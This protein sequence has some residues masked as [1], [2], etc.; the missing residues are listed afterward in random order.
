MTA[1]SYALKKSGLLN[2]GFAGQ[3]PYQSE[4]SLATSKHHPELHSIMQKALASITKKEREEI[5]EHWQKLSINQGLSYV[6]VFKYSLI[7]LAILSIFAY[8]IYRLRQA[9]IARKDSE[10]KL[11]TILDNAPIG[12]WLTDLNSHYQFINK[13]LCNAVGISEEQF[14]SSTNLAALVGEEV[15]N[16]RLSSNE[17]CLTQQKPHISHITIPFK[18]GHSH[19]L[20]ITK[21]KLYDSLGKLPGIIGISVDITERKQAEESLRLAAAVYEH[22]TEGMF[23]IDANDR[24]LA[25]NPAF[26]IITGYQA[27]EVIGKCPKLLQSKRQGELF[28]KKMWATLNKLGSWEG[29]VWNKHKNGSQFA[30]RL[31]INTI[32]TDEGSVSHRVALFS[33]ITEKKKT[34]ELVWQQANYDSLTNFPNRNMFQDRL[35][36]EITKSHREKLPI[37]LLFIDLDHFKEINDTLGHEM[38]DLLLTEAAQRII[39][40]VRES[41]TVSRL[42]GD[43]FTVIL[44]ELSD[45]SSIERIT[46]SIIDSLSQPFL[47]RKQQSYISASIG[48]TLYPNDGSTVTQLLKNADQAMYEAKK[49]KGQSSY[50]FYEAS[51]R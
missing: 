10:A 51:S 1:A 28:Y 45:T 50:N 44:S 12:I 36:Q 26:S 34:D 8:W 21:T 11:H 9:E 20:E 40:C 43:E 14:I 42:G 3:T 13:T 22:S 6:T 46:L 49:I 2:L 35:E 25:T 48:I 37:A 19:D 39:A 15:A 31:C 27:E 41:D 5:F 24:I 29:E 32:Y 30:T 38:G 18:D 16:N 47:L 4:F 17:A 23:I 33:D 7:M